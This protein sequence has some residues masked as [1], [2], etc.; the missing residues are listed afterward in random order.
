MYNK[1]EVGDTVAYR[2]GCGFPN[3]SYHATVSKIIH[4]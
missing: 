3:G 1:I 4:T 2:V